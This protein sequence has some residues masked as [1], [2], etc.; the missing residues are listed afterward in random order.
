MVCLVKLEIVESVEELKAILGQQTESKQKQKVQALYWL[1]IGAADS[2][3][4]ISVLLG[5][6]RT[7]V[8][9]WFSTYRKSGIKGLLEKKKIVGRPRKI[10]G[11]VAEKLRAELEETEGSN[12]YG[13]IQTWKYMGY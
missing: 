9:R 10:S 5:C 12:S 2:I 7:T 8:S 1:K 3:G 6:H 11:T 13:E 4:Q